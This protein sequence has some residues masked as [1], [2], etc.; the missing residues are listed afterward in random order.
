MPFPG[1]RCGV[2]FIT[3]A[4]WEKHVAS[5]YRA[6]RTRELGRTLAATSRRSSETP[7][8]TRPARY[9]IPEEGILLEF[10]YLGSCGEE[11]K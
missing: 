10:E 9:H 11:M 2:G 1:I 4:V 8:L 7:I 6:K 5:I 3:T